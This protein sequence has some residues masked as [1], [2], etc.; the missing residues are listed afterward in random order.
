MAKYVYKKSHFFATMDR[1]RIIKMPL[2]VL[3]AGFINLARI[4]TVF[5]N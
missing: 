2:K 5:D 3:Y 1:K 4:K